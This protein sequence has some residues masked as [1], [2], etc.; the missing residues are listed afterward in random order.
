MYRFFLVILLISFVSC[1][2]DDENESGNERSFYM[3]FTPF[4]YDDSLQA[5]NETYQNVLDDGDVILIHFDNGVPWNEA[6]NDLP[7]L[8]MSNLIL[9]KPK[10][11]FRPD[12]KFF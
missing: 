11:R 9:I 6:L 8:R 10:T 7:F 2:K 5:V 1:N 3:G 12:I 4:P